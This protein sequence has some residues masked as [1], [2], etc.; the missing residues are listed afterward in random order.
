MQ[1]LEMDKGMI[2]IGRVIGRLG[3]KGGGAQ[4]G[5]NEQAFHGGSPDL[6]GPQASPASFKPIVGIQ[7]RRRPAQRPG[8]LTRIKPAVFGAPAGRRPHSRFRHGATV[9]R[10]GL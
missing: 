6:R 5:Q 7:P 10:S 1:D 4:Q 2:G 3:Q 8:V 9:P